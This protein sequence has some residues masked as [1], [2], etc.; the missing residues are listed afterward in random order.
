MYP[1]VNQRVVVVQKIF[2]IWWHFNLNFTAI[3]SRVANWQYVYIGSDNDLKMNR[4]QTI[5]WANIDLHSYCRKTLQGCNSLN[6]KFIMI[7][8]DLIKE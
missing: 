6:W 7:L 4:L 5:T 2:Q 8:F 3:C 1:I